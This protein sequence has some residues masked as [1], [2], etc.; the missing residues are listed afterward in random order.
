MAHFRRIVQ[1]GIKAW[2][3]AQ[4]L[5]ST[6]HFFQL[7]TFSFNAHYVNHSISDV[8]ITFCENTLLR[9]FFWKTVHVPQKF[10]MATLP[11]CGLSLASLTKP[12]RPDQRRGGR[13]SS[14]HYDY[15]TE[16]VGILKMVA[17]LNFWV[18]HTFFQKSIPWRV[19]LP[20]CMLQS[21]FEQFE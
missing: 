20:N 3:L 11:L 10:K 13:Q 7:V 21:P 19:F 5:V 2:N 9:V 1:I 6:G 18:A 15:L 16:M 17:I 8:G 14:R 4:I 12:D